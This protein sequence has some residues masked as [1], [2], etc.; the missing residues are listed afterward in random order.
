MRTK[1]SF[2]K[3]AH[4]DPVLF[5]ST[6]GL[7]VIGTVMVFSSSSIIGA[8]RYGNSAYFLKRHLIYLTMGLSVMGVLFFI[9]IRGLRKLAIPGLIL[10]AATLTLTALT[11][12]GT[13]AKHAVRWL[14]L[15]GFTVQP[16]EFAKPLIILYIAAYLSKR[17]DKVQDFRKGLLPL[18]LTLGTVLLLI[19]RQPDF[20]TCVVIAATTIAMLFVSR[21]KPWHLAALVLSGMVGGYALIQAAAYR[22]NRLLAFLDPWKDPQGSGFQIIQSFVAFQRGGFSG[23]GLGDGVQKLLYLPEAHTDFIFSVIAEE[24]GFIGSS[25]VIFLFACLVVRGM[26]LALRIREPFAYQL[27]FGLTVLIGVQAFLNMAVVMGAVPTKGLTLPFISYGGS[28]LISMMASVGIL[29]SLFS[30]VTVSR[31]MARKVAE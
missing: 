1:L 16:S 19:L 20:G 7:L 31:R 22:R 17:G 15:G 14:S 30:T 18:L 23:Q 4:I 10:S 13:S 6:A 12:L 9:N 29:F 27:S 2:R 8:D 25:F 26:Q 5:V 3:L 21:T 28:S 11:S 24:L